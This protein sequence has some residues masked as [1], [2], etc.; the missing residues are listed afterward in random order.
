LFELDHIIDIHADN[1]YAF[2]TACQYD[3]L[4]V[5][6]WLFELDHKIDI[7]ANNDEIFR[8]RH[9]KIVEWLTTLSII[10]NKN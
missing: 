7:H 10:E 9:P 1:E 4:E 5:A 8:Y 6:R 3:H 2:R